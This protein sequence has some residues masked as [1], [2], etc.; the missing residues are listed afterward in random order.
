MSDR[1]DPYI[2]AT[3]YDSC[4]R[5]GGM[6]AWFPCTNFGCED[7]LVDLY[8]DDPINES[9]GTFVT[10]PECH[11]REGGW[12]CAKCRANDQTLTVAEKAAWE[13]GQ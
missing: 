1:D 7:G 4:P 10:C 2:D 8:E 13:V 3:N 5:C 9:P 12:W 11:G 6:W